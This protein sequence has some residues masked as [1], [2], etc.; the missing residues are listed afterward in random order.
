[1]NIGKV[2]GSEKF[3]LVVFTSQV[4]E[5]ARHSFW[6]EI[7][8]KNRSVHT[9]KA[10]KFSAQVF[11]TSDV[12]QIYLKSSQSQ[13]VFQLFSNRYIVFILFVCGNFGLALLIALL[14]VFW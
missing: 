5:M 8:R 11:T 1:M 3:S 9:R 10:C 6:V 12:F 7:D 4:T 13:S 2:Y 14:P